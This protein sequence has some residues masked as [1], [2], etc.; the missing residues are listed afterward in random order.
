MSQQ[1][2]KIGQQSIRDVLDADKIEVA[3]DTSNAGGLV[4]LDATVAGLTGNVEVCR[5]IVADNA[6]LPAED[7]NALLQAVKEILTYNRVVGIV[8]T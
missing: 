1:M 8:Q 4:A 3:A 7:V 6:S 2:I 5:I